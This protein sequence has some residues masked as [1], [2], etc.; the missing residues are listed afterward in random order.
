MTNGQFYFQINGDFGPDYSI[1]ASTNLMNWATIFTTNS[2]ALPF[3]WID[4]QSGQWP[5]Q[6][7]RVL[8]GP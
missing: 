4:T 5:A 6:F 2:P 3:N 7:Y 1:Q 8:L